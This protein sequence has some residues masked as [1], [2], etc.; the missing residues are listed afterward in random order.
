[1]TVWH[2]KPDSELNKKLQAVGENLLPLLQSPMVQPEYVFCRDAVRMVGA[3]MFGEKW[4]VTDMMARQTPL[5]SP[6]AVYEQFWASQLASIQHWKRGPHAPISLVSYSLGQETKAETPEEFEERKAESAKYCEERQSNVPAHVAS[7]QSNWQSN[8]DASRRL[9][10]AMGWLGNKCRSGAIRGAFQYKGWPKL[11]DTM[12]KQMWNG[13]SDLDRWA[14]DGG[15]PEFLNGH[16]YQTLV[17][18]LREDLDREIKTLAHSES[19]V[20]QTDLSRLPPYLKFAVDLALSQEWLVG[21]KQESV[22]V[23]EAEVEEKWKDAL[24]DIP[25][26]KKTKVAIAHV[27]GIP[28]V[29]AIKRSVEAS[30][31]TAKK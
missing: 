3:A 14:R 11:H 13:T 16:K 7:L 19:I 31:N 26:S 2:L 25:M 21:G 27:L 29:D 1:M 30:A 5:Y 10:S 15:Y 24:P 4:T 9:L 17:F 23:R 18:M 28:D 22:P 12:D 6:V 8:A 20:S